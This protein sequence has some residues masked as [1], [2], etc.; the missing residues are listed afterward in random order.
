MTLLKP[1]TSTDEVNRIVDRIQ[2]A[3]KFGLDSDALYADLL[4]VLIDQACFGVD[5]WVR[6]YSKLKGGGGF[7]NDGFKKT[8]K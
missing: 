4:Q 6:I 2:Q 5:P 7:N 3:K 1:E 8:N